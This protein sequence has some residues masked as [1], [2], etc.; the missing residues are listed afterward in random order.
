[1][2]KVGSWYIGVSAEAFAAAQ[3]ARYGYKVSVQYGADQ[4]EYDLI[5]N[6]GDEDK[7]DKMLKISVK[8]S[9]DGGWGLT[10]SYKKGR[11]YHEAID[12]WL[13]AHGEKTIFCLVQ[14]K[15][16][17]DDEMPRLYLARPA[18]IADIMKKSRAENGETILYEEH[19][20]VRGIG[21]G[22]EVKIPEAWIFT[23]E[24]ARYIFDNY[25]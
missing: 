22:T 21:K 24:R 17:S 14:F 15:D 4:P 7:K 16:V 2:E 5:V 18:E 25:A 9:Q 1:M 6:S 10:Q 13:K 20:W 3:F 11:T 19:K 8:G 12:E 23:R